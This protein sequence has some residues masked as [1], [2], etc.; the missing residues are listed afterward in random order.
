MY[1]VMLVCFHVC[2]FLVV[3]KAMIVILLFTDAWRKCDAF[4]IPGIHVRAN[5]FTDNLTSMILAHR[6]HLLLAN[7]SIK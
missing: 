1:H 6:K 4:Y 2:H 7:E 3:F 5:M